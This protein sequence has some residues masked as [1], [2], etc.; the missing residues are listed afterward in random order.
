ML[1]ECYRGSCQGLVQAR[2]LARCSRKKTELII[3]HWKIS[4]IFSFLICLF[5]RFYFSFSG[6]IFPLVSAV[7]EDL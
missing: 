6:R 5:L 7:P 3:H 2:T 1:R 4:S